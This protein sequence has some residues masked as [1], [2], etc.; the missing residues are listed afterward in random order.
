[1]RRRAAG[2][3]VVSLFAG[4]GGSSLGYKAA[5]FRCLL[6]VEWDAHAAGTYRRNFPGTPVVQGDIRTL[7][8]E[9]AL[10]AAGVKKGELDVLDGSPPC[11]GFSTSGYQDPKDPRNQL[12]REYLRLLSAFKPRAFVMENVTGMVRGRHRKVLR[13]IVDGME[14]A[15]YLVDVQVL[16]SAWF[17][18]T[19][20]RRRLIFLG[21]RKDL[22]V[23]PVLDP[24][25]LPT[26]TVI[27]TLKGCPKEKPYYLAGQVLRLWTKAKPGQDLG[28]VHPRGSFFSHKVL[29]PFG[30]CPTLCASVP[31]LHWREPRFLSIAEGKRIQGIPD[32]FVLE[33]SFEQAWTRIGNSVPPP[34]MEAVAR[35]VRRTILERSRS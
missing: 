22:G 8:D 24:P 33:G 17:G 7:K 15:G 18:S 9:D 2:P 21:A 19:Q 10:S 16:S 3:T 25:R 35:H 30:K 5:G 13:A 12:F 31:L 4:L 1:M 34:L 28:Y 23:K 26:P 11:Q 27:E 29:N 32:S 6:A 20:D 14:S